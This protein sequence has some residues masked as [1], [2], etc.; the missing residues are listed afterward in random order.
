MRPLTDEELRSLFEKLQTYVGQNIKKLIERADEPH[1]FRVIKD[2]VYY[3]SEIHMRLATNV[4]KDRLI[5]IGT[6][7][8]KFTKGGKF[9]LHVTCLDYLSQ[10]AKYKVWVK[11]GAEMSFLYGNNV[12]KAGLARI[13]DGTPKYG[14]I[15]VYSSADVPLGFGVAAQPTEYCKDLEPTA[16]VVLHQGDIG[17]YLRTEDG[18]F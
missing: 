8:G 17:E 9:R 5:S 11:P 6:C 10:Y 1:T 12:T 18:M 13:T 14:G 2:R 15:V 4:S 3:L 7:F 16:N